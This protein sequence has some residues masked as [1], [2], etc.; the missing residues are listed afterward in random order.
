MRYAL[1]NNIDSGILTDKLWMKA[2]VAGGLWAAFEIIIGS[3]LHNLRIPFAGSI[4]SAFAVMLMIAFHRMWPEKGLIWRAGLICALMKSI[5]PSALILGPMI[6]IM[7]EALLIELAIRTLGGN[8]VGY[9]VGGVMGVSSALIHKV[10]SILIL[11]GSDIVE[12]YLN[13]YRFAA[14]QTGIPDANPWIL[15]IIL[16][17]TYIAGGV[18]AAITALIIPIGNEMPQLDM[19]Q[20]DMSPGNTPFTLSANR[21][22]FP[23]LLIHLVSIPVLILVIVNT[24]LLTGVLLVSV[25][26]VLL[27]LKY[28]GA[29]RRFRK[30][31]LWAQFLIIIVISAFF[32]EKNCQYFICFSIEG[33][34]AGIAMT[35][36]AVVVIMAFSAFSIELRNPVVRSFLEN[37]GM[38]NL[39]LAMS[40][41]FSALPFM[42]ARIPDAR[43]LIR[44]PAEAIAMTL[45]SARY[46]LRHVDSSEDNPQL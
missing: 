17:V 39:Y 16:V 14:K 13:I 7:T 12:V 26:A 28:P 19:P 11:Y 1:Q 29:Y 21:Y 2:A 43:K 18:A 44:H 41:A 40:V 35:L 8:R 30:P 4:L 38:R 37:K 22:S 9:I 3:F 46:W 10:V 45:N 23:L 24:T 32:W 27:Y 5:S 6:G 20:G 34:E 25:W 42:V 31:V 36:R 33:L 15:V